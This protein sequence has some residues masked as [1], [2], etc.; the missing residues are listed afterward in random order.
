L[1]FFRIFA[2]TALGSFECH[3]TDLSMRGLGIG[4]G[5]GIGIWGYL[6]DY[7]HEVSEKR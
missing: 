5:I 6:T 1:T 4:I 2:N 7:I 3:C